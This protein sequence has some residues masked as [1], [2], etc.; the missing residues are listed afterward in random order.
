M[1]CLIDVL[2][3]N[4]QYISIACCMF[5]P[6]N[7]NDLYQN[8]KSLKE[9]IKR[10]LDKCDAVCINRIGHYMCMLL[11]REFEV[12]SLDGVA[13]I[14]NDDKVCV[15]N[16]SKTVH[17][18]RVFLE[19]DLTKRP[20]EKSQLRL[21]CTDMPYVGGCEDISEYVQNRLTHILHPGLL[22]DTKMID[23]RMKCLLPGPTHFIYATPADAKF[24]IQQP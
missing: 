20:L 9:E 23:T 12:A 22:V 7:D 5:L 16:I 15:N 14:I 10:A 19:I 17:A 1:A 2:Y 24:Y 8:L 3:A 6:T 11:K 18:G 21:V 13:V 4:G